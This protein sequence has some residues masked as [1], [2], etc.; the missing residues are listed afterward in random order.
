M[1]AY[2]AAQTHLNGK[3]ELVQQ[4]AL[5]EFYATLDLAHLDD[6][7]L[8]TEVEDWQ[9]FYNWHRIH[10]AIGSPPMYKVLDLEAIIPGEEEVAARYNQKAIEWRA[11]L[12][13]LRRHGLP[14]SPP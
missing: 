1:A 8:L 2:Q 4:T 11:T 3:V 6:E 14:V 7:Q 9:D 10:S 12:A 5:D 13:A